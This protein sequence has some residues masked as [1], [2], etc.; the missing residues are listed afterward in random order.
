MST[1]NFSMNEMIMDI[2]CKCNEERQN[3]SINNHLYGLGAHKEIQKL[4][5]RCISQKEG[6]YKY[7]VFP[8][9]QYHSYLSYT[10]HNKKPS[11]DNFH[12]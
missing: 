6:W 4:L 1:T 9:K 7:T 3:H 5:K 2:Q 12:Y 8:P 11:T 10:W